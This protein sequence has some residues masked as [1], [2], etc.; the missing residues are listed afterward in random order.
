VVFF[1]PAQVVKYSVQLLNLDPNPGGPLVPCLVRDQ[2]DYSAQSAG[3][4]NFKTNQ[5]QQIITENVQGFKVY[6]SVSS[7]AV[8]TP[9]TPQAWAGNWAV[10]PKPTQTGWT[11][12]TTGILATDAASLNTQVGAVLPNA[13]LP[14]NNPN[15]F[16]AIPTL[17]RFDVTTRSATQ[18]TEYSAT[19]TA[20]NP[21][22]AYKLQ[23]QSM[24]YVPRHSGLPMD[25]S[26]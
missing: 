21:T 6:L 26:S 22:A 17:I 24:V 19:P 20:T 23:T 2:G 11:G 3:Y 12:W 7:P 15:W 1:R 14:A 13:T 8:A 18:R 16:R 25:F 9:D 4:A 5:T 10:P